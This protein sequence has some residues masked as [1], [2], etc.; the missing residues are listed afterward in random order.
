GG[1]GR[2]GGGHGRRGGVQAVRPRAGRRP[3]TRRLSL[4]DAP[5]SRAGVVAVDAR[6]GRAADPD[7]I[8]SAHPLEPAT[9]NRPRIVFALIAGGV[10]GL[11]AAI[12]AQSTAKVPGNVWPPAKPQMPKSI[13]LA[14]EGE[15]QTFS[16]PPGFHVELVASEPLIES[17]ILMD[18]DS[19]GRLWVVEMPT[20]L[21]DTSGRDSK[22]LLDRVSVLED[23]NGDGIMD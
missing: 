8:R 20:F 19:D 23:T 1:G 3:G 2:R 14:A 10:L 9:M 21:P 17:P 12:G 4:R 5:A 15:M 11:A 18:F 6:H 13:A 16:L 7:E 22:E